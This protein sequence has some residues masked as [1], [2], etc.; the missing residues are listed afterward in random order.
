MQPAHYR[1]DGN[2][3]DLGD[4]LVRKTLD[5]GQQ[6]GDAELLGQRLDRLFHLGVAEPIEELVLGA[7]TGRGGLETPEAAVEVEVFDLVDVG[8]VGASL[9]GSVRV[10][11]RV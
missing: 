5:I 2:I 9:L 11:E 10:D 3:E 1:T 8:L 7:A 6:D 4:L